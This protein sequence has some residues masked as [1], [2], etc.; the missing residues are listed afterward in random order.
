MKPLLEVYDYV[1]PQEVPHSLP[2]KRDIQHKI[3]LIP[4]AMLPNKLAYRCNPK[5]T[6]EIKRQVDE[7]L[8][9]GLIRESLSPCACPT[10]VVPKKNGE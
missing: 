8:E 3:D 10:L 2:P 4:G 6:E 9:K 1:F 5:E 7:L